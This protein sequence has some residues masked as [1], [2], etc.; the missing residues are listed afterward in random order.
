MGNI[1]VLWA[2]GFSLAAIIVGVFTEHNWK[3]V[4]TTWGL[5]AV[6]SVFFGIALIL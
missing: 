2:A 3:T 6:G 1:L 5:L 4:A